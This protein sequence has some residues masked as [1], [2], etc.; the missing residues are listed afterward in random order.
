M[1][2]S[3]FKIFGPEVDAVTRTE[4]VRQ[5]LQGVPATAVSGLFL[6]VI[7]SF[8]LWD[9]VPHSGL[10]F[11]VTAF[12]IFQLSYLALWN[13]GRRAL[14]DNTSAQWLIFLRV[15]V[16]VIGIAW[17]ALPV[18]LFPT[19]LP[20]Q[21]F[22]P[23]VAAGVTG[24]A[25][26]MLSVDRVSA[27]LFL[28]SMLLPLIVR[29]FTEGGEIHI[30]MGTMV[31]LYLA[32]LVL[33]SHRG[34]KAFHDM[35]ALRE[36]VSLQNIELR[37]AQHLARL[38]S[39][40][41]DI[42]SGDLQ[43]SDEVYSIYDRDPL[44]FK[45]DL[46]TYYK[47]LVHPEDVVA[48]QQAEQDAYSEPG[49][50]HS[51]DHRIILPNGELGW[52]HVDGVASQ[53]S[54]GQLINIIGTVQDITERKQ[55]EQDLI[56]ARNEADRA[57][58]AKSDFISNMSHELRTPMNAILG[59]S[60]L[61]LL[62]DSM[63]REH[64]ESVQEILEAGKHLLGLIN[65]TL[66]LGKVESGHIDLSLETIAVCELVN[67]CLNMVK[68]LAYDRRILI[69]H[70]DLYEAVVQADRTRLKQVLLNLL[71]NAIKYNREG[72]TVRIE[73]QNVNAN[74]LR[75]LVTDSGPGIPV[76]RLGELFQPFRRLE[77]ADTNIEGTGI[78]LTI[79]R[80]IV[81]LMGGCV[82]VKSEIGVGTTFWIELPIEAAAESIQETNKTMTDTP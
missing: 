28:V 80:R 57:N 31:T 20:H 62:K 54:N 37:K 58:K 17:G 23:F 49:Q 60:Q 75:I 16:L 53:D 55:N 77:A 51:I 18:F 29:L 50:L 25:V 38:G 19:D 71:S 42:L 72:G 10:I 81:E 79:T 15:S 67:E 34:D 14:N 69:S 5:L 44:F 32:Y 68:S 59:F 24:A 3:R 46:A 12:I 30:A 63:S 39:W 8:V 36:Q 45:P 66:D 74:R 61:L 21:L 22:L 35:Q 13:T 48:V 78:G 65:E 52:V 73:L 41:L 43:W 56:N 64:K 4:Q 11:W 47:E 9:S 7:T 70:D 1:Q 27:Q 76:H 82:D 40:T 26:A 33:V 6:S 2:T